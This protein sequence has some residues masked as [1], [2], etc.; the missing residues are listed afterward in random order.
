MAEKDRTSTLAP[1]EIV[2][3]NTIKDEEILEVASFLTN[4]DLLNVV[5]IFLQGFYVARAGI[6]YDCKKFMFN[7]IENKNR[8]N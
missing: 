2:I 7:I 6:C 1:L 3:E 4:N 5:N 8:I